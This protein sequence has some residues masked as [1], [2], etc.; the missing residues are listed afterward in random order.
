MEGRSFTSELYGDL[1]ASMYVAGAGDVPRHDHTCGAGHSPMTWPVMAAHG[2]VSHHSEQADRDRVHIMTFADMGIQAS[3]CAGRGGFMRRE[4]YM[5]ATPGTT[6]NNE[7]PIQS[8]QWW[9]G[10][11]VDNVDVWGGAAEYEHVAPA[12][13]MSVIPPVHPTPAH[14]AIARGQTAVSD[15]AVWPQ[16][17][18]VGVS[19]GVRHF[20]VP[21]VACLTVIAARQSPT[22]QQGPQ[23]SMVGDKQG[24]GVAFVIREFGP[25]TGMREGRPVGSGNGMRDMASECSSGMAGE[26]LD[27]VGGG[28][29]V[30]V[31]GEKSGPTADSSTNPGGGRHGRNTTSS[32]CGSRKKRRKSSTQA[33]KNNLWT[34]DERIA[35][36]KISVEDDALMADAKRSS[37]THDKDKEV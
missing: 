23:R 18:A 30:G 19:G 34:L 35:P 28:L 15:H 14:R 36:V 9:G 32:A 29:A 37:T 25:S 22:R 7:R 13:R 26:S 27:G 12:Q 2:F 1:G 8:Y 6:S 17:V 21:V 31:E 20:A 11:S 33:K 3:S 4:R 10:T 16:H 24:I 5:Q